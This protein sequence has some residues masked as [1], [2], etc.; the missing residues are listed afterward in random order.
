MNKHNRPFK[1]KHLIWCTAATQGIL[2]DG[3]EK[4]GSLLQA[5]LSLKNN[6]IKWADLSD[7]KCWSQHHGHHSILETAIFFSYASLGLSAVG[8]RYVKYMKSEVLKK[9]K[10]PML[11]FSVVILCGPTDTK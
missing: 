5:S 2:I 4:I 8:N 6:C 3:V 1:E 7:P 11:V 9:V 10:I